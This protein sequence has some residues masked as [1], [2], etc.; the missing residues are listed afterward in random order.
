MKRG[1]ISIRLF[2]G[3]SISDSRGS[4]LTPRSIKTQALV[5]LIATSRENRRSR[6]WLQDRLWS[7]RDPK[8][9]S[10]SLR[11]ALH[12]LKSAL[13]PYVEILQTSR[14]TIAL[15]SEKVVVPDAGEA[16]ATEIE[17]L[18]GMDVKDTE[19]NDWLREMRSYYENRA[20]KPAQGEQAAA[21][22][23]VIAVPKQAGPFN[24]SVIAAGTGDP[25]LV[26]METILIE[27]V[28]RSLREVLD[29]NFS[30]HLPGE[31]GTGADGDTG[32]VFRIHGL[33][34]LSGEKF[35]R[36]SLE[37][38]TGLRSYWSETVPIADNEVA[39]P[40]NFG[41][42]ALAHR[43]TAAFA[44]I[45][46]GNDSLSNSM[47]VSKADL[48]AA[49]ALR[50]MFTMRAE[51]VSEAESLLEDAL[52]EANRGLYHAW[53]AQVYSIQ[54]VE[55]Q[56]P[57]SEALREKADA[58]VRYALELEPM[59]SNV[60]AAAANA[61]L[62]FDNDTMQSGVLARQAVMTN[63]GNPLC[64]FAWANANL[65]AGSTEV[66][67]AAAVTAQALGARSS[68]EFWTAFQRSLS[69]A[70]TGRLHEAMS[71]AAVS[72]ALAPNFRPPLRYLAGIASQLGRMPDASRALAR[73]GAL[74]ADF[75]VER[76]VSDPTYPV[77]MMRRAKL[78]QP[79]ALSDLY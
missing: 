33:K 74:E 10:G 73:L 3:F 9:A 75:S 54:H 44:D 53:L 12:D 41:C 56:V 60:L 40:E 62:I 34:T 16:P 70:V 35:M 71:F 42:Q 48:R 66:A 52:G 5:A 23:P 17:F 1:Q 14:T 31:G 50:K 28:Q 57:A 21:I 8:Q 2:G 25:D 11:T 39:G 22:P 79:E 24:V 13:G 15:D 49:S 63:R 64:W 61:R 38:L 7:D 58:H 51:E 47:A 4:D 77:S 55:Q 27:A 43:A 20:P 72:N 36:A 69:A 18:A 32:I 30:F 67:Y 26:F 65:Y 6:A 78:I 37:S 59:N 76:M 68:I 19:F 46:L 29:V 45:L